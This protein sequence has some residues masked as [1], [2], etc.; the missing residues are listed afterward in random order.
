MYIVADMLAWLGIDGIAAVTAAPTF[1]VDYV[2]GRLGATK[3]WA[4]VALSA[5]T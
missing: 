3:H 4:L 1:D 5:P 2:S